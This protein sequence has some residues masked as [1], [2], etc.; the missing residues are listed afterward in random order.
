MKLNA[1]TLLLCM[2]VAWII[3]TYLQNYEH[4]QDENDDG[5]EYWCGITDEANCGNHGSQ[6]KQPLADVDG[7]VRVHDVKVLG[8]T[9]YDATWDAK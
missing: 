1:I 2:E 6:G 7:H 4:N 8:E 5:D 9:V 3:K